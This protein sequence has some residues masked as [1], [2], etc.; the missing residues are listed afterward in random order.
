[1]DATGIYKQKKKKTT[2]GTKVSVEEKSVCL[3]CF[4]LKSNIINCGAPPTPISVLDPLYLT[5]HT[6]PI[7][8]QY[9]S[10]G[11]TEA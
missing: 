10:D 7:K 1:M 3:F 6:H 4:F 8:S 5:F 2:W 9:F 11:E